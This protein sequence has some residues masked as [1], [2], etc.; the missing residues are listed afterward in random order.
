MQRLRSL[1]TTPDRFP[2]LWLLLL[3]IFTLLSTGRWTVALLAWLPA[4]F[5]LRFLRGRPVRSGFV[6]LALTGFVV[7]S[8]AWYGLLAAPL[9]VFLVT[10]AVNAFIGSLPFLVDRLL[11]PR[12]ARDGRSPFY[13]TLLYPL[14]ATAIEFLSLSANPMGSFGA[15]AYSQYGLLPL[16]QIVSLTGLWGLT[17]LIAW[18]ASVVNWA[19]E[20][21]FAWKPIRSGVVIYAAILLAVLGYGGVRLLAAPE[22]AAQRTPVAAFTAVE[23]DF[24]EL[25]PL[26]ESDPA[27]FRATTTAYHQRYLEQTRVQ[28]QAGARIIL[29]PEGAGIGLAADV[30]ALTA[31]AQALA[32][33]E[34]IYLGLPV[35]K[36]F[37][38]AGR[39]PENRLLLIDPSGAIV[40]D[41]VKYGGN[42]FEGSLKGD[43]VL[44]V[45][46]TPY[47]RLAGVICWDADFPA[48][49]RQVGQARAGLLLIPAHDWADIDP[50]HGQMAV[51]RAIENGV[52]ILRQADQG[53]SLAAD[54]YGRVLAA[55][56]HFEDANWLLTASVAGQGLPTLYTRIG[57]AFAWLCVLGFAG[58]SL[59]AVV[60][61][62]RSHP[63]GQPQP[64]TA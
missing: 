24:S 37:P 63:L 11:T 18:F 8:I 23:L 38:G 1:L 56:S 40:T 35:F 57:D 28:A 7:I 36:L 21:G 3:A 5:N 51:F 34:G 52:S 12:L 49:L 43:G 25:M 47:G 19:W 54:P 22:S 2:W 46:D 60:A 15:Q 44:Q 32:R 16:M 26:L 4:I 50:L 64:Q 30:E 17:F 14:A 20:Q 13:A 6:L 45:V 58:L 27:A 10:M 33:Q 31:A 48:V 42:M 29:W 61:G 41:H 53:L 39:A 62:R 55:S 59:W 9:P